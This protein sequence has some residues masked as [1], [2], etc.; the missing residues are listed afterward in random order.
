[1]CFIYQE[2]AKN[3]RW[4]RHFVR[5]TAALFYNFPVKTSTKKFF[6]N[7][8]DFVRYFSKFVSNCLSIKISIS[9][10]IQANYV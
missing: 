9:R 10:L 5:D 1:M 6:I 8:W 4:Q 2:R 3:L 7:V